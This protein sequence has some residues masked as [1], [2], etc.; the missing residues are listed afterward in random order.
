MDKIDLYKLH[1]KEYTAGRK[2]AVVA[3]SPAS[4]LSITGRGAPG[5]ETF[6]ACVT[7]LYGM[8]YTIKMT[9]KAEGRQDYVICKL[10]GQYWLDGEQTDFS[11]TGMDEWN[12]R[13]LIRTPEFVVQEELDRAV[14]ALLSKGKAE[15]ARDVQLISLDE[16]QCVQM[17]HVGPYDRVG[18][19]V[20]DMLAFAAKE[21]LQPTGRHHEIYLSDPRRVAPEKLKTIVRL[22]VSG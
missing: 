4:Y 6:A 14:S 13:L 8:A 12:W 10:E 17:L 7:A 15:R 18:E 9:G 2:P 16:G 3:A 20:G 11:A 1:K 22:P 19:T 21:N 5:G